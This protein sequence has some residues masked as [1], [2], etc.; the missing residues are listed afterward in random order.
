MPQLT[1][2]AEHAKE[3]SRYNKL[4]QVKNIGSAYIPALK[5]GVLALKILIKKEDL[6][7][8]FIAGQALVLIGISTIP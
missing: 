8:Y 4:F 2:N 7:R 5:D 1:T 3:Y 6:W